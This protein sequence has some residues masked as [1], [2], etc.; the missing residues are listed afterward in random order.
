MIAMADRAR[1]QVADG[2]SRAR[3]ATDQ[4]ID[5]AVMRI[6]TDEG[7]AAVTIARVSE[8]SGVARTTLYRRYATSSEIL[9]D[10]AGRIAPMPPIAATLDRDGFQQIVNQL[11]QVFHTDGIASLMGHVLVA[12]ETFQRQWRSQFVGTRLSSLQDFL[13]RGV[14]AGALRP[15]IDTDLLVEFVVGSALA[16]AALRGRL[17]DDWAGRVVSNLWPTMSS[18]VPSASAG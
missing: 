12:N 4:K 10:V 14:H 9:I 2:R 1:E 8:V 5:Q 3:V 15:D 16:E 6:V 17:L 18:A 11:Q 7:P 13:Q